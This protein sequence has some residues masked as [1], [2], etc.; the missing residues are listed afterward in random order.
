MFEDPIE[1]R[2]KSIEKGRKIIEGDSE[3]NHSLK[4][5]IARA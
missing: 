4:V 1:L 2:A 5:N 3:I